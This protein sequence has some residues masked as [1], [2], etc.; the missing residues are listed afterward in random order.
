MPAGK[1]LHL[2]HINRG[3]SMNPEAFERGIVV[4]RSL[5]SFAQSSLVSLLSGKVCARWRRGTV[6]SVQLVVTHLSYPRQHLLILFRFLRPVV[7]LYQ[8]Q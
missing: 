2:S 4:Y 8:L 1:V 5:P 3:F 7:I 6:E